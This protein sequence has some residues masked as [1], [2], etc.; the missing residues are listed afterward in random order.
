[1]KRSA[2]AEV[3]E[4]ERVFHA[5][6]HPSRRHILL[7]LHAR[8]DRVRAGAIA[9]RFDCSWPTTS[10]HLCL[11]ADAGLVTSEREGR[12]RFYRLEKGLLE[13]VVGDWI[14]HFAS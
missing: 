4:I 5:L 9:A 10:R 14:E 11:L 1:M 6:A 3:D 7:V 2:I 8:G 12:E 13:R